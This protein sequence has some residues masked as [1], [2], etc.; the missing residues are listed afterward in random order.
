MNHADA[1][2]SSSE[3]KRV[4][5]GRWVL[6]NDKNFVMS[7]K[8]DSIVYYYN[9]KVKHKKSITFSFGDSL[10]CYKKNNGDFNF[11]KDNGDIYPGIIIKEYDPIEKDTK[12]IT[13]IFLDKTGMDLMGGGRTATFKKIK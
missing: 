3:V 8:E 7:I 10:F 2:S 6:A 12:D 11:M 5:I 9:K 1:Q 13:I 4:L